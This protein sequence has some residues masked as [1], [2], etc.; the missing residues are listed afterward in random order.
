MDRVPPAG[1]EGVRDHPALPRLG[2]E[3]EFAWLVAYLAVAGG[4]LLRRGLA[5][6]GAREA[7]SAPGLPAGWPTRTDRFVRSAGGEHRSGAGDRAARRARIPGRHQ[8]RWAAIRADNEVMV[9]SAATAVSQRDEAWRE[10]RCSRGHWALRGFGHWALEER[11]SGAPD[12]QRGP[13]LPA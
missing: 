7:G 5:L 12:R 1:L 9:P 4:R 2:T 11:W 6:D 10:W 8:S 3:E 13:L